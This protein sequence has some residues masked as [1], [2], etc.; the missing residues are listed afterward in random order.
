MNDNEAGAEKKTNE[1]I[2]EL[3]DGSL[4][5][6]VK[7]SEKSSDTPAAGVESGGFKPKE[8]IPAPVYAPPRFK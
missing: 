3:G 7:P 5:E 4:P 2:T 6:A 1:S 8:N